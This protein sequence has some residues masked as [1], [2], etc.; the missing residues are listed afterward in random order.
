M[1]RTPTIT[2]PDLSGKRAIV[3][4]GSDGIGLGLAG[5]LAAAGAEVIIPVR[6][7]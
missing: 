5:R 7:A 1:P 3:T 2:V 4:G 6:N